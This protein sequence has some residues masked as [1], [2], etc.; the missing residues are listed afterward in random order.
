M[1]NKETTY[2]KYKRE[3]KELKG[4]VQIDIQRFIIDQKGQRERL[5]YLIKCMQYYRRGK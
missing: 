4:I 5:N 1:T 2:N 3:N